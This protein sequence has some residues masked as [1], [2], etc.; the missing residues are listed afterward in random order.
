MDLIAQMNEKVE[1]EYCRR[2]PRS[3]ASHANAKRFM[4][5]GDTRTVTAFQPYPIC[6]AEGCGC[7]LTDIDGNRYLDLVNN[8]TALVHGHAHPS[9]VQAITFQLARGTGYATSTLAQ[10]ALAQVLCERVA[11][12]ERVRFCNSGT[13]A[14]MFAIRAAKAFTG[15]NKVLKMEGGYHGTHDVAQVSVAPALTL[16]GPDNWPVPIPSTGAFRGIV[17]EVIVAPFNDM[18]AM[19][20]IIEVHSNETAAIIVEPVLGSAGMIPAEVEFLKGLRDQASQFGMLL[21]FDEVVTFRLGYGGAQEIYG[22]RP[23]L[24]VLGKLIGGGLAV[25]AF[26]GRTDVMALF[27]PFTGNLSHSGTFNGNELTMVAG[28]AALELLSATEIAR[29]NLLGDRLRDG[30]QRISGRSKLPLQV[31]GRGSLL[32]LHLSNATIRDYRTAANSERARL[33]I[34][35]L[36]MLNR[37]VSIAPRGLMCISTPMS[38]CEM[39]TVVEVLGDVVSE[40]EEVLA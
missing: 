4:P 10:S 39:D 25:G 12:I 35:H 1:A 37:G 19:R 33:H 31:T 26:G 32:Q 17:D 24:T 22:V 3:R 14:T 5:G 11:G 7:T 40:M 27:D 38:E 15:R 23:D 18:D 13:E 8:Y 6:V 29:I 20:H 36:A 9:I 16:A 34:L 21:I 28:L 2:T 30:I